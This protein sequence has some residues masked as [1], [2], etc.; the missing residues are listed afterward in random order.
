MPFTAVDGNINPPIS[1]LTRGMMLFSHP[2]TMI[3]AQET[4]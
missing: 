4:R 2:A 3:P 1:C